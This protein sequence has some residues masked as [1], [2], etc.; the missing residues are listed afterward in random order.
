MEKVKK[1]VD[2]FEGVTLQEHREGK[3]RKHRE[4]EET[5]FSLISGCSLKGPSQVFKLGSPLQL[6]ISSPI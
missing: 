4:E 1:N 3:E 6:P 2:W 5:N